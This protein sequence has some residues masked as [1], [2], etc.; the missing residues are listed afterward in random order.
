MSAR[1]PIITLDGPAGSGKSTTAKALAQ[2]LGYTYLDTGA[3]YRAITLMVLRQKAD[4][5]REDQ[6]TGLLSKI[7]ID[8]RH[9]NG[10][11]KT[12]LNGED[13]SDAIRSP[14][15]SKNVSMV[16]G[17]RE[18]RNFLVQQQREIGKAGGYVIDGRDAGTV[19]FP[20]AEKKFFLT[21][22]IQTRVQRRFKELEAGGINTD[23]SQLTEEIRTRDH[24]DASR[25]ESPL[26]QPDDAVVIDN[27][28][29]TVEE[30]VERI[31][32]LIQD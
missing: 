13:V 16:S 24:L 8:I 14:E 31:I 6:V 12:F 26:T 9:E 15:V 4:P 28:S 18:V 2:R 30:Q 10:T 20:D 1:K 7:H 27:S 17:I 19:I 5:S 32:R 11:Q 23:M 21:A 3:M 25:T 29:L 22:D